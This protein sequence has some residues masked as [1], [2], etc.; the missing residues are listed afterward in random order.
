MALVSSSEIEAFEERLGRVV[1]SGNADD[2]D[3]IGYGE[4]TIAV[5]LSTEHGD[6]VCKRLA[7]LSST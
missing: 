5:K 2:V 3:V 6:F 7:P 1:R 4:V